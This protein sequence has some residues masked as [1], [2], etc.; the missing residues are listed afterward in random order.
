MRKNKFFLL[1][2]VVGLLGAGLYAAK[3]QAKTPVIEEMKRAV[4]GETLLLEAENAYVTGSSHVDGHDF[5][6]VGKT[7]DNPAHPTSG[8][9]SIGYWAV[10][11][12]KITWTV[13]ATAAVS[14]ATMEW[15]MCNG[16]TQAK[17]LNE[18]LKVTINGATVA[19][20]TSQ[21]QGREG[22]KWANWAAIN[23]GAASFKA[24]R[25]IIVLE[26][27]DG[28]NAAVDC[29]NIGLP[30]GAQ[31]VVE[32]PTDK[33]APT[34]T[35]LGV[36][37]SPKVGDEVKI[38]YD[39]TDDINT[40]A[41]CKVELSVTYE[42]GTKHSEKV[43]VANGKFT[44]AKGGKYS[45]TATAEDETGNK[46]A[47]VKAEVQIG[48]YVE[49]GEAAPESTPAKPNN[50]GNQAAPQ[51][52]WEDKDTGMVVFGVTTGLS[53]LLIAAMIVIRK[54]RPDLFEKKNEEQSSSSDK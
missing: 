27:L 11:G 34:L 30:A 12:N 13:Q 41:E 25:N 14:G 44:A 10:A 19:W 50:G 24:G 43:E 7:S 39:L 51:R 49:G 20:Q 2:G 5:V 54:L 37:G 18:S 28:M 1:A 4:G 52:Q 6:E 22:N 9:N 26:N 45:I 16:D 46:T 3:E 21:I 23:G 15:W 8:G 29:L 32:V 36:E 40:A 47:E 48:E 33:V 53:V 42:K 38:K 17:T 31:A 35:N